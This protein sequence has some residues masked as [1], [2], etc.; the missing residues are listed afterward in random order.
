MDDR[1]FVSIILKVKIFQKKIISVYSRKNK[2]VGTFFSTASLGAGQ[3]TT[4]FSTL[5]FFAHQGM[6]YVSFGAKHRGLSDDTHPHGGSP[7]GAGTLTGADGIL[8][9]AYFC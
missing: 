9:K 2:F 5:P 8:I 6:I 4:A 3:E 1:C 7:W